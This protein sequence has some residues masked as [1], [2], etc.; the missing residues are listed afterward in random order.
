MQPSVRLQLPD[1]GFS[2]Q[3]ESTQPVAATRQMAWGLP[4]YG[5]TVESGMPDS[6]PTWYFAEGATNIMSLFYLVENPNAVPGLASAALSTIITS[7]L[8]IVAERAMYLNTSNRLWEGGTAGGG[9]TAL[10]TTWSFAEGATGFF[11]TYLL[12]GNP[13]DTP[14]TVT[15]QYQLPSGTTISKLYAVTG[16]SRRTVDI[17]GEDAQLRLGRGRDVDLVDAA[18]RGRARDVVGRR[19]VDRRQRLDRLHV[20]RRR[21]GDRRGRRGRTERGGHVRAGRQRHRRHGHAAVY[22]R[23]RRWHARAAGTTRCSGTRV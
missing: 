15:V 20:D 2:V 12:F 10:S 16:R 4:I 19:P 22:R 9:A 23:L 18:D 1:Q 14:A 11:R 5:S 3:V 13:N 21:L 17:N 6:S 8:P 7:D